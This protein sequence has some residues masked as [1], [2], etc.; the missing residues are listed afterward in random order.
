MKTIKNLFITLSIIGFVQ[1]KA[2]D[3]QKQLDA[4]KKSYELEYK[5]Y[6]KKAADELKKIY[7]KNSYEINYRLGWLEYNAGLF[8]ESAA[9][10]KKAIDLKP[11]SE[12]AR[13]GLVLPK[14][15][16]GKWK[17]VISIYEEILKIHPQ[18]VLANYRLGLIYYGQKKYSKA[19]SYFTKVVNLYPFGHDGLLMLGWT[20]YYLGN[21][22]TSKTLFRKVLLYQP[23]DK[24]AVEGLKLVEKSN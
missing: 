20:E 19:K 11:Y 3:F 17:E 14:A 15:A 9:Y 6:Y 23:D 2:Q 21:V 18:N 8:D 16:Q 24:S 10:Y 4:F 13:F 22:K 5:G 12:E 7:D 1:V